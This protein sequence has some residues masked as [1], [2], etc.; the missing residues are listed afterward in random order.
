[1][2]IG[3]PRWDARHSCD[4][5]RPRHFGAPAILLAG[6]NGGRRMGLLPGKA[7]RLEPTCWAL[8]ALPDADPACPHDLA[9]PLT[10]FCASGADGE[11]NFAFHALALL[12]L[13]ARGVEHAVGERR[14]SPRSS[15]HAK[16]IELDQT[17]INRQNN[18]F[19]GWSWIAGTFS[20]V[21]PTAWAL[22]AL[23]SA[24]LQGSG[25]MQRGSARRRR[26]SSIA[27]AHRAAGTTATRTCSARSSGLT[28]RRRP[29]RCWRCR[30]R[31]VPPLSTRRVW[32]ISSARR[33]SEAS[34]VALSLAVMALRAHAHAGR[35]RARAA[36]SP[37]FDQAIE[38]G[39]QL[40]VAMA[41]HTLQCGQARCLRALSS[42]LRRPD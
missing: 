3:Y 14:R 31:A 12:T 37:R 20:W 29:W 18:Q 1:M 4:D 39:H 28:F 22:L 34:A 32:H 25:S 26:C 8:L 27:A 41:L 13:T 35:R 11:A 7:S 2:T 6:R 9:V 24:R 23:R 19:Q 5:R 21:E 42:R 30:R 17:T 38:L 36:R 40:G 10:D 33:P 16:G 15:K